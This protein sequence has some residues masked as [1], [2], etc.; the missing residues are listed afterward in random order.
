MRK[1]LFLSLQLVLDLMSRL[2]VSCLLLDFVSLFLWLSISL[3]YC[4]EGE[5]LFKFLFILGVL[6]LRWQDQVCD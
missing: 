5:S 2:C 6:L 4:K 3:D 1:F